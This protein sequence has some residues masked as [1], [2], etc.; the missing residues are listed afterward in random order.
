MSERI[1]PI[2]YKELI[3]VFEK[4]GLK[5]IRTKGDHI[6]MN[7]PGMKRPVIIQAKPIIAVGHIL[8]N[9]KAANVTRKE[10]LEALSS[11]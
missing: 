11:L 5:I 10:Y 7:K 2:N 4:L 8:N 1:T 3:K 6:I 9:I